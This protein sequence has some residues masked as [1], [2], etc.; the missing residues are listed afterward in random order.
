MKHFRFTEL[1]ALL[2][3]HMYTLLT[4]YLPAGN[5]YFAKIIQKFHK[6][7]NHCKRIDIQVMGRDTDSIQ[8]DWSQSSKADLNVSS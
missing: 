1:D 8:Y 2:Y 4:T 3:G 5:N 7:V 6:L